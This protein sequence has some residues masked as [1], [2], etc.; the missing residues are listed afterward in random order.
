MAE[1]S[2][3]LLGDKFNT[4]REYVKKLIAQDASGGWNESWKQ[5]VTPWDSGDV[6][7]SLQGLLLSASLDLPRE[8]RALV[9]GCGR[10]YDA[11]LIASKLGLDTLGLDISPVGVQAARDQLNSAPEGLLS[12]I[13]KVSYEAT[14][15]FTFKV[16]D[17]QKFSL[18]Y[19]YTFFVAIPPERRN[20]WGC[21]MCALIKPGGYLITLVFPLGLPL[22]GYVGPPFHVDPEDYI[23]PLGQGWEKVYDKVPEI[24]REGRKGTERMVVWRRI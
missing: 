20:E 9:P 12:G 2:L 23:E 11:L 17:D 15:F 5:G 24:V 22:E 13:E 8:G 1:S 7:L 21:Q 4:D 3:T 14:D 18:I 6:Q 16:P 10:G 19:D